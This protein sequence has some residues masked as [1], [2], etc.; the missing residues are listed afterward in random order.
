MISIIIPALNEEKCLASTLQNLRA[1]LRTIPYE[2]IVVDD[3][4]TDRT[5]SIAK[6]YADQVVICKEKK[7][8]TIGQTRNEGARVAQGDYFVFIDADVII[9]DPDNFFIRALDLFK[10]NKN[11]VAICPT[12]AVSP[13]VSTRADRLVYFFING[14]NRLMNNRFRRGGA[15]GE[16]QMTKAEAF[17]RIGG[18]QAELVAAEDYDFFWRL[19]KIGET[20]L[21]PTLKIFHSGRRAHAIGWPRLLM[22]WFGNSVSVIVRRQAVSKEWTQIR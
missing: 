1:G 20:R 16:C 18:Y 7:R 13:S 6:Q 15:S 9:P 8:W 11:L 5:L 10:K 21:E 12:I 4:S 22:L 3:G 19:G 14:V 17:R 2:I